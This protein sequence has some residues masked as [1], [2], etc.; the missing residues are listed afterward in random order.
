MESNENA[1]PESAD[2]DPRLRLAYLRALADKRKSKSDGQ[3]PQVDEALLRSY[4]VGDVSRAE[5]ARVESCLD[6]Y[7]SWAEAF[8]RL[9]PEYED[10]PGNSPS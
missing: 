8:Y 2:Y 6:L 10:A 9:A 5:S 1:S 3:Q 4:L 7:D